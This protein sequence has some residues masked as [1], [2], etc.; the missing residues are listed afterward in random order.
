[1]RRAVS[2]RQLI[3]LLVLFQVHKLYSISWFVLLPSLTDSLTLDRRK[4]REQWRRKHFTSGA[5]IPARSAGQFFYRALPTFCGAPRTG[6]C[7]KV[8]STVTRTELGQK[9][10]TVTVVNCDTF[11]FSSFFSVS[12][13]LWNDKALWPAIWRIRL[14]GGPLDI[15]IN[16]CNRNKTIITVLKH[17][18]K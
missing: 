16:L 13:L 15:L 18:R 5:Q 3:E 9:C 12:S 8:Q 6:H 10:P 2:L 11:V 1:M 17:N 7:R 4:K 14:R